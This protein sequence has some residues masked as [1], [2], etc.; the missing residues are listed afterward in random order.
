MVFNL[1][2][3]SQSNTQWP[4]RVVT[5]SSATGSHVMSRDRR[6]S[7]GSSYAGYSYYEERLNSH[8]R[9]SGSR[10]YQHNEKPRKG[11]ASRPASGSKGGKKQWKY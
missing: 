9:P 4:Q 1:D 7:G 10:N 8:Y 5:G 6:D 2:R 3:F 11:S